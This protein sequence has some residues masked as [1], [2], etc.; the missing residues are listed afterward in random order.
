MQNQNKS[1]YSLL[2]LKRD[3]EH[4]EVLE[5]ENFDEIDK[6]WK[7]LIEQWASCLHEQKPFILRRP[8]VTAFDP[9]LIYEI[10]IRPVVE[11]NMDNDNPYYS[12]AKKEGF[13]SAIRGELLDGGY[14]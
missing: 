2:I 9:G 6:L 4:M 8:V 10:T 7:E 3:Q 5:T 1:R 12:R 14:K 13:S 11:N